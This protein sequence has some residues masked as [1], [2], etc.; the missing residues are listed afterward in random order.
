[1]VFIVFF[2]F[3]LISFLPLRPA[4]GQSPQVAE[5]ET[6]IATPSS[7]EAPRHAS[8]SNLHTSIR[9]SQRRPPKHSPTNTMIS[10]QAPLDKG[11]D[12]IFL[13][14]LL[15]F[16]YHCRTKSYTVQV[17]GTEHCTC[18][19]NNDNVFFHTVLR[20]LTTVRLRCRVRPSLTLPD[21]Y[22]FKQQEI[23]KT[24]TLH[25]SLLFLHVPRQ[26]LGQSP[27]A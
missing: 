5:L 22:N 14:D 1:M 19:A 24:I 10:P 8:R 16:V 15:A 3:L 26:S 2:L 12:G 27:P 20:P 13:K 25:R 11:G 18:R 4:S 21:R 23:S 6:V 9:I 17:A 7:V